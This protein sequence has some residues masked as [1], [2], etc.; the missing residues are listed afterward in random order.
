MESISAQQAQALQQGYG[1]ALTTAQ[2]EAQRYGTLAGTAGNLASADTSTTAGA[3]GALSNLGLGVGNLANSG[4]A[5][6]LTGASTLANLGG[7]AQNLALTGAGAL[8]QYG[9]QQQG[10]NQQNLDVAYQ[11]FLRQ[12]GWPQ[13]QIDA[14]LA[15]F[16][17]TSAGAPALEQQWGVQP[18]GYQQQNA[19]STLSQI[20]SAGSGLA[21]ILEA[22][23]KLR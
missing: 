9:G 11:D 21:S 15:T 10:I 12:Q 22:W 4:V 16:K 23:G 13:A 8:S 5:Q 17:D 1:Q 18:L 19:P 14:A 3:A 6:Q 2:N 7:Q 20:G